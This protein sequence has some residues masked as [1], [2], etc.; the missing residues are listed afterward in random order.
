[1]RRPLI[2]GSD[3]GSGIFKVWNAVAY[4]RGE[5]PESCLADA[6]AEEGSGPTVV[7]DWN[8]EPTGD[9]ALEPRTGA[10][11]ALAVVPNP[12]DRPPSPDVHII[13]EQLPP[14]GA[15]RE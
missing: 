14:A 7:S 1:R 6:R 15:P 12:L 3:D 2:D 8:A 13:R 5:T 4:T 10:A 9:V 11:A